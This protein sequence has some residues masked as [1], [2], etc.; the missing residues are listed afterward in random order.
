MQ[1]ARTHARI[2]RALY[3]KDDGAGEGCPVPG[4]VIRLRA[5]RAESVLI[6][7]YAPSGRPCGRPDGSRRR[8]HV[9]GYT[10][11]EPEGGL[12]VWTSSTSRVRHHCFSGGILVITER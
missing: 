11:V 12:A 6:S 8:P 7:D 3:R 4:P 10:V 9:A 1:H 5:C 2:G